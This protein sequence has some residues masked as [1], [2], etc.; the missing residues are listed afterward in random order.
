LKLSENKIYTYNMQQSTSA[1]CLNQITYGPFLILHTTPEISLKFVV[2]SQLSSLQSASIY[3]Q[4]N[5]TLILHEI[6][7]DTMHKQ[8]S[9]SQVSL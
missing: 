9:I 4:T 2:I 1:A 3:K 6:S 8:I 5:C 7:Y